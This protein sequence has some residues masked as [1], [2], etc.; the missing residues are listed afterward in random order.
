MS[1]K[2]EFIKYF[3]L[4]YLCVDFFA[5]SDKNDIIVDHCLYVHT[6][7]QTHNAAFGVALCALHVHIISFDKQQVWIYHSPYF[8]HRRIYFIV[9]EIMLKNVKVWIFSFFVL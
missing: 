7:S 6:H 2:I 1:I 5:A 8:L 3:Y 9:L 4:S